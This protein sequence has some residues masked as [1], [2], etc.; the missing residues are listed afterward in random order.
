M[1]FFIVFVM[2]LLIQNIM[3][4]RM[5]NQRDPVQKKKIGEKCTW[6]VVG[7]ECDVGLVCGDRG[8]DQSFR[9]RGLINHE[10]ELNTDCETGNDCKLPDPEKMKK[11]KKQKGFC[12]PSIVL[13]HKSLGESCEYLT[14]GSQC[15]DR[16]VCGE[17]DEDKG[18]KCRGMINHHCSR[19]KDCESGNECRAYACLAI[20]PADLKKLG[21]RC[22][23]KLLTTECRPGMSCGER[24]DDKVYKCRGDASED[25]QHDIDC[26]NGLKC[27]KD[28]STSTKDKLRKVCKGRIK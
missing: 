3:L 19:N 27:I 4:Y 22:E 14:F 16:L 8:D 20:I 7:S 11:K 1:K 25:C 5:K 17:R 15:Q 23:W 12:S 2:A 18:F 9:C 10:C 28:E 26:V 24:D 21:E 13:K 6:Q